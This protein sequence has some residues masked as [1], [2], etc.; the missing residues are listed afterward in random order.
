MHRGW[1]RVCTFNFH[2]KLGRET[3]MS[4]AVYVCTAAARAYTCVG[5]NNYF[6]AIL[7]LT[8]AEDET[9]LMSCMHQHGIK[10][11]AGVHAYTTI[12]FH[13]CI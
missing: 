4:T 1:I 6:Y 7:L 11:Y 12:I 5:Y 8:H 2:E 10:Y 13:Q 9:M 3:W